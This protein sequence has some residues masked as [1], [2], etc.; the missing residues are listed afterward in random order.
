M[1]SVDELVIVDYDVLESKNIHNSVYSAAHIGES[2][3][4]ALKEI[5]DNDIQ[6]TPLN[7]KYKEGKTPLPECDLVV[8]CRDVV[9][10]RGKEIDVRLYISGK[11]LILD[12][13]KNVRT[14]YNYEGSYR[15]HLSKSDLKKAG[16]FA[17]LILCSDEIEQLKRNNTVQR[18]DLNLLPSTINKAMKK[19]LDNNIDI[20]YDSVDGSD[21]LQCLQENIQPILALN[22]QNAV[23]VYVG[24]RSSNDMS[25]KSLLET[26]K[27][28]YALIP[29]NSLKNTSELIYALSEIVKTQHNLVNFIVTIREWN[30]EKFV[31]LLEETGAA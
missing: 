13:R 15:R 20:I 31:E 29:Q 3:V 17:A 25:I 2:K 28:K 4:D 30:G 26:P 7:M 16:F 22:T 18:I 9:C 24:E 8:D 5:I 21:R 11:I 14:R 23:K 19:S 27:T 12:C 10:D 1:E 6:I